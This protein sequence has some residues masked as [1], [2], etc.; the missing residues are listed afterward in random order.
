MQNKT[1]PPCFLTSP[2]EPI[3]PWTKWKKM[4]IHYARVC[5]PTLSAE[6][7]QELLMHCL[8]GEGQEVLENLP[9]L[10]SEE[11]RNL[12]EFEICMLKL[13]KHYLPRKSTIMELCYFGKR[14]QGKDETVEEY[15]T[16]LRKLAASSKFGALVDER[17]WDQFVLKCSSD[18]IIEELWLK[19]EPPLEKAI[20]VAKRV[21]RMMNC[22]M[23]LSANKKVVTGEAG[24]SE[25]VVCEVWSKEFVNEKKKE[26]TIKFKGECFRCGKSGHKANVSICPALKVICNGYGKGGHF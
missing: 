3:Y 19:D 20:C 6:S 16:G 23:E 5:G 14:E 2:G 8:G 9:D 26:D 24:K 25:D 15:I 11:M 1:P 4:F 21:E 10:N 7:K 12:N 17:I 18:K 22:V 13:D